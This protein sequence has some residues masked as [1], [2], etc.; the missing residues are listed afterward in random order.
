MLHF[1]ALIFRT[2]VTAVLF[3]GAATLRAVTVAPI[4]SGP[5]PV[6]STNFEVS[7]LSTSEMEKRLI[8]SYSASAD[9]Y[10]SDLLLH[11]A[12]CP[13]IDVA[14]PDDSSLFGRHADKQVHFVAYIIYPTTD[15]NT[16]P[17][18]VFPYTNTGDHTFPHMQRTGE[19]PLL[20]DPRVRYP[21][22]I[23]SHGYNAHG[24]WDLGHMKLLAS[25]GY[26][27]VSLQHGDGRNTFQ[28]CLGERPLAISQLLDYLLAHPVFGPA[29]DRE[30]IGMTGTSLGGYTTFAVVGGGCNG[31]S[32]VPPD[33]RFHA[34]FGLVPLVSAYYSIYPFGR[35]YGALSGIKCP[36]FAV[37][38]QNDTSVPKDT[39]EAALPK[40]QGD[41]TGVILP[42]ETHS[43]SNASYAEAQTYEILFFN[44]WLRD[45]KAAMDTLYGDMNVEGGVDDRRTYRHAVPAAAID[46][47]AAFGYCPASSRLGVGI[48]GSKIRVVFPASTGGTIRYDLMGSADLRVWQC[49]S[50]SEVAPTS[51]EMPNLSLP[52][53]FQWR[54]FE[55]KGSVND[56]TQPLFMRVRVSQ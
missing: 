26:I 50:T 27:V 11:P 25:Q 17:D 52:D 7:S 15:G 38:A 46:E 42:G 8:G 32:L 44:A 2:F 19:A 30:R 4:T 31:S 36:F 12:D 51:D 20:R 9:I 6:G 33:K 54:V 18:Y 22:I 34:A 28:G 49:L 3:F 41:C 48:T 43:L 35:D 37:Y 39:V 5:F 24:L 14:M 13:S 1:A 45:N 53:G 29:I 47:D 16:R 40:V 55:V 56:L 23:N 10:V 21:L